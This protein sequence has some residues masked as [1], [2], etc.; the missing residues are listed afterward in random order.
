MGYFYA[1]LKTDLQE[2]FA[3]DSWVPALAVVAD[4]TVSLVLVEMAAGPS[5]VPCQIG[6]LCTLKSPAVPH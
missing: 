3:N 4:S 5:S 6:G 1:V 2:G